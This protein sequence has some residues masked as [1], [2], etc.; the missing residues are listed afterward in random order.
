MTRCTSRRDEISGSGSGI[1]RVITRI[2]ST[3]DAR[4]SNI[5]RERWSWQ[6]TNCRLVST[7]T[8]WCSAVRRTSSTHVDDLP[9]SAYRVKLDIEASARKHGVHDDDMLHAYR[10]HLIAFATSDPSATMFVGP[11]RTGEPLEVGVVV[12]DYGEAIHARL[13]RSS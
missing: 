4:R 6:P 11:S 8:R 7:G 5:R 3:R 9:A 13:V 10:H 12:D 2:Q 1:E